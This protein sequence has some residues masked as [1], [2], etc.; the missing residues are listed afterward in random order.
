MHRMLCAVLSPVLL[1]TLMAA[2]MML[3]KLIGKYSGEV[4][5]DTGHVGFQSLWLGPRTPR[6][7]LL[8]HIQKSRA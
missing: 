5:N 6:A 7:M 3:L 2:A 1:V 4:V 8:A